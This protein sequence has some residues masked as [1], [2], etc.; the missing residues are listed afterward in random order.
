MLG[1]VHL[2]E[3]TSSVPCVIAGG[4]SSQEMVVTDFTATV[5]AVLLNNS[6]PQWWSGTTPFS[7]SWWL[8]L[9]VLPA[10]GAYFALIN[11][12]DGASPNAGW[13]FWVFNDAGT[14]KIH[15]SFADPTNSLTTT[16]AV[17][18]ATW[19]HIAL[20]WDGTTRRVWVNGTLN[21]DTPANG[22]TASTNIFYVGR[23]NGGAPFERPFDG[24]MCHLAMW[25]GFALTQ[26]LVDALR[27]GPGG[28]GTPNRLR[29]A[30]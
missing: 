29:F 5:S 26:T 27:T 6:I 17:S 19:H 4:P 21:S 13:G 7:I 15:V 2:I 16:T 8:Y 28:V 3:D 14:G 25:R 23:Q 20:S 22:P 30:A 24:R 12:A 11:R 1:R 9:D 18:T 10:S